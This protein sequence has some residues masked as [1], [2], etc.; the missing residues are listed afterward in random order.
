MIGPNGTKSYRLIVV[1]IFIGVSLANPMSV[2][3]SDAGFEAWTQP[4]VVMSI[5][6]MLVSVGV[7]MQMVNE[8]RR[9][10]ALLEVEAVRKETFVEVLK[11]IDRSLDLLMEGKVIK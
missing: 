5:I 2:L 3:S 8:D 4:P 11:R 6:G 9:R 7:A 1:G 10:I